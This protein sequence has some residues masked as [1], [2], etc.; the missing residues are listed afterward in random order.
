MN[1]HIPGPP[2]LSSHSQ[3]ELPL[4]GLFASF[5]DYMV[6]VATPPGGQPAAD[7]GGEAA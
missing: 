7:G 5:H 4:Q 3:V 2:E 6:V 1:E